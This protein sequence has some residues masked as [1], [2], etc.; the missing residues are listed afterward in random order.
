MITKEQW[1][2]LVSKVDQTFEDEFKAEYNSPELMFPVV[3]R[4]LL[5]VRAFPL[6]EVHKLNKNKMKKE[7]LS[8]GKTRVCVVTDTPDGLP[9]NSGYSETDAHKYYGGALICES[10]WRK[11]DLALISAAPDMLEALQNLENDDN[12]I[13]EHAWKMVQ[14]AIRKATDVS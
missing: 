4:L 7:I 2:S 5:A 3:Q 8:K 9:E 1:L 10:V 13:P 14:N 11:K 6:L 12:S